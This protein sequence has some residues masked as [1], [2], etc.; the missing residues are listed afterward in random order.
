MKSYVAKPSEVQ[1]K[2]YVVDAKGKTLGRLT[3]QIAMVLMGK[4]K[5]TYTPHVD[6]G[7]F[8][9]VLN[10]GEVKLTGKKLDQKLYRYHTGYVGNLQE[11]P[12]RRMMA[13]KPEEVIMHAVKG[14]LPKNKLRSR[15]MTRLRV[16]TGSVHDHEAQKPE[17]LNI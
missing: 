17:A 5:P 9:I 13:E 10:A 2:W 8:V 15:M 7:D 4:N 1:R 16:Y 11:I 3:S 6:G 14:M 12:Y